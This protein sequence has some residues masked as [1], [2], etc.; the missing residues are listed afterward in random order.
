MLNLAILCGGPSLERGIS[1]NSARSFL[2]HTYPLDIHLTVIYIDPKKRFF[3]LTPGQLYSNTPSDFDFKLSKESQLTEA[4]LI[5]LLKEMDLT[6]PV[7]HGAY[8]EDG[9]LQKFFEKNHIPF[10]GSPSDVCHTIFNKYEARK[11]LESIH[12][13]AL[14]FLVINNENDDIAAFWKKHNLKIAIIKPT[15]SGS[16]IGVTTVKSIDEA[17]IAV[18]KLMQQGFQQ[19]LLEP[20][21]N[22]SEFT[23]C[24]LER[25]GQPISLI[26]L[27]IDIGNEPNGILDFRKKYL[28]TEK[29]RYHCPP[30]YNDNIINQIRSQAE[31]LFKI[32]GLRDFARIDGW[33]SESGEI[34]FSDM[35]PISGM[36]QNSFIF[37]QA[38]RVGMTHTDLIKLILE[39]A[40][41]RYGKAQAIG[42][43]ELRD[44]AKP[45]HI[46]LGGTSSERHVSLMSGINVWLKLKHSQ[47]YAP[48]PFLFLENEVW[49]LPYSYTLQHTVD[50]TIEL[51]EKA[52]EISERTFLLAS[53]IRKQLGFDSFFSIELPKKMSLQQFLKRAKNDNA[54]VFIALHGGIGEDG[55]LQSILEDAELP[56]NGSGSSASKICMDKHLTAQKIKSLDNPMILPIP[57]ISFEIT[58]LFNNSIQEIEAFW[59]QAVRTLGS[60]DVIIK[61]QCDGCS[62]GVVHISSAEELSNYILCIKNNVSQAFPGLFKSQQSIIQMPSSNTSQFLL[63]AFIHTDKLAIQGTELIYRPQTGW[64][65]MTVGVLEN[66][67]KYYA[68]PP[69]ITVA[70]NKV[71]S[72]EEKFQGGTGINITPPPQDILSEEAQAQVRQSVG[73]VAEALEIENYARIDVFVECATGRIKVIEANTLPALTPST[74]I[75]HQGLSASPPLPPRQLLIKIIETAKNFSYG[76]K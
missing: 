67:G 47:K 25:D 43:K 57:Q 31:K 72:V 12:F 11:F 27:E 1:L 40:L 74:V 4:Q 46:L 29:T 60:S 64:V 36:E 34:K 20:F 59:N 61:P 68:L 49:Q 51:C 17:K 63:E 44:D 14:P 5:A 18:A 38:S 37:Q 35:N 30:R 55:R 23:V 50:E 58:A 56:F 62:T 21:C 48:T 3:K 70:E 39:N 45:V 2:D 52:D 73:L 19:L 33:V 28:P 13:P 7:I 71:L 6:F 15:I 53:T 69:S 16:S 8:G 75:Y 22:D 32:A 65:E 76:V 42:Y 66:R 41:K 24:V 9:E 54:F 10:V 26:P